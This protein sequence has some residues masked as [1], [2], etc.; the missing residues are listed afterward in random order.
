MSGDP[1][2][3]SD[4][5]DLRGGP[6]SDYR[7]VF[8]AGGPGATLDFVNNRAQA[9]TGG[10]QNA[11]GAGV[12]YYTR[13]D[14]YDEPPNLFAPYWRSTLTRFTVDR[15]GPGGTGAYDANLE[16]MFGASGQPEAAATF[17]ELLNAG[18]KGFQ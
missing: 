2:A 16:A 17:R 10:L 13:P 1:R 12:A 5:W 4:P 18:Y 15:P 8:T 3:R 6:A 11:I 7:F 9:A 14:H